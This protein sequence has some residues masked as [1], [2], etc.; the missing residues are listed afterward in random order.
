MVVS[1]FP[2]IQKWL[3]RAPG[4]SCF[5]PIPHHHL[6]R[7]HQAICLL[8]PGG[9]P[10][11]LQRDNTVDRAKIH[12]K[13]YAKHPGGVTIYPMNRIKLQVVGVR[14]HHPPCYP[15]LWDRHFIG[16][17]IHPLLANAHHD[18]HSQ[19]CTKW[20]EYTSWVRYYRYFVLSWICFCTRSPGTKFNKH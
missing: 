12:P 15:R 2:S 11:L 7:S 18:Q 5:Y 10:T 9:R 14:N 17:I 4:R 20:A 1:P 16:K 6:V 3:F 13:W 19:Y 8:P